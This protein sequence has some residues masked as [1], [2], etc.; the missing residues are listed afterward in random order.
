M[1]PPVLATA[2]AVLWLGAAASATAGLVGTRRPPGLPAAGLLTMLAVPGTPWLFH[3]GRAE[4]AAIARIEAVGEWARRLK[5]V[6]MIGTGLQQAIVASAGTAPAGI[7]EEVRDLAARIQAGV[8]PGHAL[9]LFADDIADGVCD[10]VVAALS[11]HLRDRGDRLGEVL[12]SIASAASAEAATRREV[13]AKRTQSRFAVRF[14]TAATVATLGYGVIRPSY[15]RPYATPGG[16]VV[17]A[18]LGAVFVAILLWVRSMSRPER[19]IRF[20]KSPEREAR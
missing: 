8:D 5:D 19:S 12:T 6:S 4:R 16:Q 11:L 15:M 7:A 18:L 20:L 2:G 17:M 14:L 9:L 1:N 3:V 13:D 10:Q